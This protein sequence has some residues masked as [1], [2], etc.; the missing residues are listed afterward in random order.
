MFSGEKRGE[1][2]RDVGRQFRGLEYST[3]TQLLILL[4]ILLL[5]HE[6][7]NLPFT[8]LSPVA[9]QHTINP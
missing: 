5:I 2:F 8:F 6:S 4:L 7:G 9:S 3:V 1:E